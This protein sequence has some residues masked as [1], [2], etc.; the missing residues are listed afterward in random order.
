ML[1]DHGRINDKR[2]C[3]PGQSRNLHAALTLFGS[4]CIHV[5]TSILWMHD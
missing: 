5:T 1:I 2:F 4:F 3:C